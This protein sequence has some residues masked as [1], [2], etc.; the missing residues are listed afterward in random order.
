MMMLRAKNVHKVYGSLHKKLAVLNGIDI[1]IEKGRMV[2]IVGPSGAGKSTLLHLLA[3]LDEPSKG[4]IFL[5]EVNINKL[6]DS[7]LSRIRNEKIGFVFQFYH[8]LPEFNVL[9]NVLMPALISNAQSLKAGSR[10]RALDIL[11]QV[12]LKNRMTHFPNE[13]SGGEQQRVAISRALINNPQ[14][15]FCDEPTGNL[16]SK[17]GGEIMDLIKLMRDRNNMTVVIVTH[18]EELAAIADNVFHLRD[19]RLV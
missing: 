9:E 7:E 17:T 10:Q 11:A 13:L 4:E 14:M 18:N 5:E 8:L 2:S 19:G 1:N 6:S 12:G 15:L 3:G 16:D